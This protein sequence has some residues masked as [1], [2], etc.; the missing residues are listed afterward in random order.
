MRDGGRFGETGLRVVCS[1]IQFSVEGA[2]GRLLTTAQLGY[3][4]AELLL[5][6]SSFLRLVFHYSCSQTA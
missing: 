2:D 4:V 3:R 6:A 1:G 5:D